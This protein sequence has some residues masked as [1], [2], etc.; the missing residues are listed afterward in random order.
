QA[1]GQGGLAKA[2]DPEDAGLP[3]PD[4]ARAQADLGGQLALCHAGPA[5]QQQGEV[6]EAGRFQVRRLGH[7]RLQATPGAHAGAPID[8]API[9]V[10]DGRPIRFVWPAAT[11]AARLGRTRRLAPVPTARDCRATRP[12]AFPRRLSHPESRTETEDAQLDSP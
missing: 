5:A 8:P 6:A 2:A 3:E 11:R 7:R 1:G 12:L 9:M 4:R 10:T